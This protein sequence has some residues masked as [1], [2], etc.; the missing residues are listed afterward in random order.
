MS[1]GSEAGGCVVGA[2]VVAV[3][4]GAGAGVGVG[5]GVGAGRCFGGAGG[6][7]SFQFRFTL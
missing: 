4:E 6:I 5:A 7:I 3:V 1:I 2:G